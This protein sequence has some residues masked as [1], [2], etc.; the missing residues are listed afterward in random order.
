TTGAT[1]TVTFYDGTSFL[2]S[3]TISGG[4]AVLTTYLLPSRARSLRAQYVGDANYGPSISATRTQTVTAVV[5][6]GLLPSASYKA[7]LG[8]IWVVV[9]DFNGDGK[10]DLATANAYDVSVLLGNGEGT[11]RPAVT[12]TG[13]CNSAR[14]AV[15]GDFNGDGKADLAIASD[16][17]L[18]VL[19]GNG[20]GTFQQSPAWSQSNYYSFVATADFNGDGKQDL[21]ALGTGGTILFL[22]NGDGTFQPAVTITSGAAFLAVADLNGDGKADLVTLNT[23]YNGAVSVLLGNGDGTFQPAV[24]GPGSNG[25]PTAFDVGD[26]NGDGKPDVVIVSWSGIQVQLGNGDGSLQTPFQSSPS[27]ASG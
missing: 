15:V 14:C 16:N 23:N 10:P 19:L 24:N 9:G 8:P 21:V 20:D 25:Y 1:G 12:S 17:G 6:N 3:A 11:F 26:F 4:Q 27:V 22:G 7:S 2:G 13:A 18:Y 5:A